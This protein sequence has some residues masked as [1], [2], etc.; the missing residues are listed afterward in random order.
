MGLAL[1]FAVYLPN[2]PGKIIGMSAVEH[3][4]LRWNYESDQKQEDNSAEVT[5]KQGLLMAVYDPKTWLMMGTLYAVS[6]M[7][8][9]IVALSLTDILDI[10]SSGRQQLFSDCCRRFGFHSECILWA[11]GCKSY[12]AF[13]GTNGIS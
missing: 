8:Q 10:H 4:W 13:S 9:S 3:E 12:I 2:S 11:Y 6:S 7:I 5:A 1:I